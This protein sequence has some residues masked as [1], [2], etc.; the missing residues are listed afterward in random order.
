MLKFSLLRRSLLLLLLLALVGGSLSVATQAQDDST[1]K[2][3]VAQLQ[4]TMKALE[5]TVRA[6]SVE[7][8]KLSEDFDKGVA[9]LQPRVLTLERLYKELQ[10]NYKKFEGTISELQAVT[11]KLS[12]DVGDLRESFGSLSSTV[13]TLQNTVG[14]MTARLEKSE[15]RLGILAEQVQDLSELK[16]VVVA[17][18]QTVSDLAGTVPVL[19]KAVA[20]LSNAQ[21]SLQPAVV[22]LQGTVGDL[23]IRV[24]L[25]EDRLLELSETVRTLS[26]LPAVLNNLQDVVGKL[27][28]RADQSEAGIK[29]L[30]VYVHQMNIEDLYGSIEKLKEKLGSVLM[31]V[32]STRMKVQE[33]QKPIDVQAI[34][35]EIVS[36]VKAEVEPSVVAVQQAAAKIDTMQ[37]QLDENAKK[38]NAANTMALL[39][40]LVGLAAVVMPFMVK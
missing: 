31:E 23:Y 21:S 24:K 27:L 40:L 10:F 35:S 1:L 3:K 20:D 34:K 28:V 9:D 18:G 6:L 7:V 37:R 17:L 11:A 38:I 22:S 29:N 14:G 39:A 30:E 33:L 26:G 25:Y 8:L 2:S 4:D 19:Q 15:G 13:I 12:E 5:S 36:S 32:E 16:P